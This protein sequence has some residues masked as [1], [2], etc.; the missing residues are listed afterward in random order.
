MLRLSVP[1]VAKNPRVSFSD[2]VMDQ[3]DRMTN[4]VLATMT[5]GIAV[6]R[7]LGKTWK[8]IKVDGH[9]DHRFI[10]VKDIGEGE[11]L[12]QTIPPETRA[13]RLAPLDLL[14]V[15]E[16]GK[17]LAKHA[18]HSH[19]WHGPRSAA[20]VGGTIMFAEYLSNNIVDGKRPV[21]CKVWRSRDRGRSWQIVMQKTGE[22]VRHFHFLQPRPGYE[23]QWW[24]TSGDLPQE[25]HVWVTWDDGDS[26]DD[27]SVP[28]QERIEVSGVRYKRDLFRLTD[29]AWQGGNVIWGTD[30]YMGGSKPPGARVFRSVVGR[31][32]APELV[33]TG[34]WHF[35]NV[36]DVGDYLLFLSQRST[37]SNAPEDKRP[38]VYL[39]PKQP[40]A[41][42]P[43]MVHVC[44]LDAYPTRD[45]PGFTF[46]KAS[47]AAVNG[48]FF[49]YRSGE[50]V[51]PAGHKILE[52]NVSFE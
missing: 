5:G 30:D 44:D 31:H 16:D 42:A 50:D 17:V 34:K 26:W 49:S 8:I 10:N 45:R 37:S 2:H 27:I 24:L 25:C 14:V 15:N 52:W 20:I 47:R 4:T 13:S 36:V 51:F 28:E 12:I 11:F 7:D 18:A 22:E 41:G 38:G 21:G 39:V 35:R 40:V 46:S 43:A 1:Y 19:R 29:L 48:T 9:S 33:G 32:L 23:N 3:K 6:S